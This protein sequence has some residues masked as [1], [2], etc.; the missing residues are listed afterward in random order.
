MPASDGEEAGGAGE[1]TGRAG[2]EFA[3]AEDAGETGAPDAGGDDETGRAGPE[4][5]PTWDC[6]SELCGIWDSG[7]AGTE[8]VFRGGATH[9][10]QMVSVLVIKTVEMLV[11]TSTEVVLP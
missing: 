6:A 5:L 2:T 10:V 4:L 11:L 3:W 1:D 8:L 9:W 7:E